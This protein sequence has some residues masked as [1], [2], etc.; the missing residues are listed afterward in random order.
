M[1]INKDA[2]L[3][4]EVMTAYLQG[5]LSPEDAALVDERL[6]NSPAD[7]DAMEALSL[8]LDDEEAL[9]EDLQA[10][11][12]DFLASLDGLADESPQAATTEA[13][14]RPLHSPTTEAPTPNTASTTP[15]PAAPVRGPRRQWL[16]LAATLLLLLIPTV[17]FWPFGSPSGPALV[18][19]YFEPYPDA[20]SD[21]PAV[22]DRPA[23]LRKAMELYNAGD[24]AAAY[25]QFES[26]RLK[27]LN[28]PIMNLYKGVCLL[29][30]DRAEAS[31]AIL[32][33]V[34]SQKSLV[35]YVGRW[36]LA[37][38]Y[39]E[40]EKRESARAELE[41]LAKESPGNL[42]EEAKKILEAL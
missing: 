9:P 35:E 10:M 13:E 1:E 24:F 36:Y 33:D 6:A 28:T 12:A 32:K 16:A 4:L 42:A 7:V 20:Y 40:L 8:T 25:E 37:L 39:L 26:E 41:R 30:T 17:M 2:P 22:D 34:V 15:Q 14:V 21:R 31:I 3:S 19:E 5:T 18:D 38:A 29:A 23:E 11:E 27:G